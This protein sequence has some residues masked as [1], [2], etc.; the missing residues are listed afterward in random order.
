MLLRVPID[1][2]A[3]IK[4]LRS[5]HDAIS[6]FGFKRDIKRGDIQIF[7]INDL[8]IA[9]RMEITDFTLVA[10][11]GKGLNQAIP[12]IISFARS[13]GYGTIRFHNRN[14]KVPSSVNAQLIK[15][16]GKEHVFIV[17]I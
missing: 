3:T 17:H 9:V 12:F 5:A 13:K 4:L 6:W 2:D 10:V 11:A 15:K 1:D 16:R 7:R 8:V 14:G